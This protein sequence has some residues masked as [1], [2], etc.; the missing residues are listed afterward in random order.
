M[1]QLYQSLVK[2]LADT[3]KQLAP[4]FAEFCAGSD[5]YLDRVTP[6]R[7]LSISLTDHD[8]QQK[9]AHCNGHYLKGMQPFS[10]INEVDLS[11]YDAVLISGGSNRSGEVPVKEH[12]NSLLMLPEHLR[13]NLHTGYQSPEALLALKGRQPVVSFDLPTSDRVAREVYGLPYSS[14]DFRQLYLQYCRDFRTVA[15]VT[16]GLAP[17]DF[18]AGEQATIDFLASVNPVEVVFLIFRPT[19]G[20]R[21]ADQQAPD[22]QQAIGL[23]AQARKA[24]NCPVLLGCMRPAGL[25]RRNL[26]ILAWL[27]GYRR[28][29][30]PD[31][32][33]LKIL[34]EHQILINNPQN[35]C[36]LS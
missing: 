16:L 14:N 19:A 8:C 11:S 21:M 27:H 15:H 18:P 10:K 26:D 3:Y 34:A 23:L 30:M 29:V 28:M 25:Y 31:H 7:T 2:A 4:T 13:I 17:E 20:T 22:L 32:Q 12:L 36:A 35:C 5:F 1:Q 6:S 9:C 33:L 24:C